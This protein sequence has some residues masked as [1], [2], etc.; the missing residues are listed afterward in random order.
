MRNGGAPVTSG[1]FKVTK[2]EPGDTGTMTLERNEHW[3][4]D[5]AKLSR[6]EYQVVSD[7][8]TQMVMYDN[9]EVD[10]IA[11]TPAE[12]TEANKP[13]GKR[14]DELIR[15]PV[16]STYYFGFFCDKAPFDEEKVRQAFAHAIDRDVLSQAI[17]GGMYAPQQ[18][19]LAADF[20]CGGDEEFQ[21][22]FDVARARQLLSESTYGGPDKL[23]KT[24]ILVSEPGGAT[25]PG[26]WGRMAEAIQQQLQQNLG[27]KVDVVRKVYGTFTEQQQEAKEI[28]G[29]VIFRL[30]FGI[31]IIDPSYLASVIHSSP[32]GNALAYNNPEV[33]KLLD[34][35]AVETDETKRCEMY[36]QVDKTVSGTAV[37]AAPFRGA[38]VAFFKPTV[39][40]IQTVLGSF[41]ASVD[42]IYIAE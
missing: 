40:G 25:A 20:P 15:M 17:L 21:P 39:R 2:Y 1:M 3:W 35:A 16:D 11:A 28:Q 27:V 24:T 12:Y 37:F 41:D 42:K 4:R 19:I 5:P 7:S 30:S 34:Q 32:Q 18:R 9:G 31:A 26:V 14:H 38:A 36:T 29:G 6:I 8:Q 13:G 10:Q 23:P 33:D 22:R